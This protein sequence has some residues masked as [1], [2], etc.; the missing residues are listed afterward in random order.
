MKLFDT[1]SKKKRGFLPI[2]GKTAKI[3][4]CGPSVY[5]YSHIGNFRT[6]LFEDILVRYLI[7]KGFCVKR[8]M[9]ITDI[10][11]KAMAQAKKENKN[12]E[13]I[14]KNKIKKFLSDFQELGMLK[15]NKI[16]K[17]SLHIEEMVKLIEKLCENGYCKKEKDGIYFNIK[18]Y[19]KYGRLK[20][21]RNTYFGKIARDDYAKEGHWDFR[22][23]KFWSR[24]DGKVFWKSKFGDGRPGWHIECSAI[25]M[26]YLGE[27]IDIHCGG[28]DNIFPHHENEIAQSECATGKK[29]ANFWLHAKHLTIGKRKMSKRTG[30]VLYVDPLKK[31]GIPPKCLRFYLTSEKYRNPLDFTVEK[32]KSRICECEKIRKLIT[33]LR[34]IKNKGNSEKG[35]KMSKKLLEGFTNA[36]DDDLNTKLAYRRIFVIFNKIEKMTNENK[37]T[38]NDSI[39]IIETIE[40]INYVL[41]VF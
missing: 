29:F 13:T 25:A 21:I 14:Q 26:H 41:G 16:V 15:P 32:F 35:N 38:K 28:T 17:A 19:K 36:M 31:A 8:I 7:F 27:T 34:K 37:L 5:A 4:T 1:M 18:K 33:K 20:K 9:N 10:E 30:N 11:D 3:Y 24:G 6:Y 12:M 39:L 2:D 22:L 40:K 23:W